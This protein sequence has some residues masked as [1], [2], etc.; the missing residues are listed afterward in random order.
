MFKMY[1]DY[2]FKLEKDFYEND[3]NGNYF[4]VT[5][6]ADSNLYQIILYNK[7]GVALLEKDITSDESKFDKELE[8]IIS[9]FESLI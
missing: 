1:G 5:K 9:E 3:K 7:K 2:K 4:I 6:A 8:S